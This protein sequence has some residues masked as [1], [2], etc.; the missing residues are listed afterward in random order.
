[1]KIFSLI[2]CSFILLTISSCKGGGGGGGLVCDLLK[3]SQD[4]GSM[5][6]GLG[7]ELLSKLLAS[8]GVDASSSSENEGVNNNIKDT[9]NSA[10]EAV[11][12]SEQ[13]HIKSISSVASSSTDDGVRF[14]E[15]GGTFASAFN[16]GSTFLGN[17]DVQE[18][19]GSTLNLQSGSAFSFIE[20]SFYVSATGNLDFTSTLQTSSKQWSYTQTDYQAALRTIA[21]L[22]DV[23]SEVVVA[24]ID[25]G[26]DYD[27]PGLV[28]VFYKRNGSV[29]GYNFV[30]NNA[31]ADDDQGHGTHC[32]GIIAAEAK[33]TDPIEGVAQAAA[34]GKVKIMPIK[35]LGADGGG[36]TANINKGIRFAIREG[37]DV[38]SMSLGGAVDFKE[39][40]KSSGAESSIIREAINKG[41]IVIVAAGNENCPLGGK[42]E[43]QTLFVLTQTIDQY[44][45]VPCSNNGV[46]CVGA[47]DPDFTLASYSN[48]PSSVSEGVNPSQTNKNNQR[49][50]PDIV[51]P[52]TNIYSTVPDGK[53]A[54]LSGT[55]MA[56][57]FV[58]G[59]AG[60]Y[61]LKAP[62]LTQ[63]LGGK[64]PQENFW[65]LLK[66]S[67]VS[68]NNE[69]G[70]TRSSVGQ[71]DMN[72]FAG[73]LS[74]TITGAAAPSAPSPG[75]VNDPA[76]E[77]G[78][79]SSIP[80]LLGLVCGA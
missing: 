8:A 72:Y 27:H 79:G 71:V 9:I 31:N 42:C 73:Q 3:A 2:T 7:T 60:I 43:Q 41:I 35:V 1:M 45:V 62:A 56:T 38:I 44:T 30:G 59:L 54:F 67:Q 5:T 48:Y 11:G 77:S 40:L 29:V 55:S 78:G 75:P 28:D 10:L 61:K 22:P 69:D 70:A 4:Q 16:L 19:L 18:F 14:L 80:D 74:S 66:S 46:I 37:A 20:D 23:K 49:L 63:Q 21:A 26:V 36:S 17:S 34:P 39:L 25:T 33:G 64:S 50:S 47:S 68:L 51:A 15:T 57:P 76:P 24:V 6:V 32:A 12:L 65:A 58:A 13:F 52:G 53:F